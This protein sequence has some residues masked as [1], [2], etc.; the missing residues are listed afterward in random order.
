MDSHFHRS[1]KV[2]RN[3]AAVQRAWDAF[4]AA[5]VTVEGIRRGELAAVLE[6]I[7]RGVV[8]DVTDVGV[9]GIGMYRGH[10]GVRQFWI[11]WFELVGDV[12]TN[13]IETLGAGDK[14]VC[15]CRQTGSGITSGAAVTWEFSMVFTMRDEKIVRMDMYADDDDARR[16]AGLQPAAVPEPEPL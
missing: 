2:A 13:V 14:V 12:Q 9:P 16:A 7:D 10:R 8:F 3:I 6:V 1:D 5:R 11:D 15:V 4:N